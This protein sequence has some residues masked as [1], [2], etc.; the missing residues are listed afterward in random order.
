LERDMILEAEATA[1]FANLAGRIERLRE[2][3]GAV[4]ASAF[5][6]LALLILAMVYVRPSFPFFPSNLVGVTE[7]YYRMSED[8]FRYDWQSSARGFRIAMPLLSYAVG[9]R[10]ESMAYFTTIILFLFL[11][12]IFYRYIR[13]DGTALTALAITSAFAFSA[14]I[15]YNIFDLASVEGARV[16]AMVLMIFA[17]RRRLVFWS[18]FALGVFIHEGAVVFLPFFVLLRWPHRKNFVEFAALDILPAAL[19]VAVYFQFYT[20]T[21]SSRFLF[22]R[23]VVDVVRD[24]V[25]QWAWH[26]YDT[27]F[28]GLKLFW[29]VILVAFA[30]AVR[31]RRYYDAL[32]VI[33]PL[34][35]SLGI[36]LVSWDATRHALLSAPAMVIAFD[37][38]RAK[39]GDITVA[40]SFLF[41]GVINL[42]VPQQLSWGGAPGNM[43]SLPHLLFFWIF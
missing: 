35:G 14:C 2:R 17:A 36:L 12:S 20:G 22:D 13:D 27:V 15:L 29:V 9:L 11:F 26:G 30:F 40:N 21:G 1:T 32:L 18:L 6:A 31:E 25:R 10:G 43:P 37:Q 7:D 39:F 19:I 24:S 41:L 28:A 38:L 16:F 34:C 33:G 8:P 42:F 5:V 4:M 23:T 3:K